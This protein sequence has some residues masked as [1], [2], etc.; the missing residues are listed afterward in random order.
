MLTTL[1]ITNSIKVENQ[2]ICGNGYINLVTYQDY[3]IL[4]ENKQIFFM[5][6]SY[7]N[8]NV[9]DSLL[10]KKLHNNLFESQTYAA[11]LVF[12]GHKYAHVERE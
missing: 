2:C 3:W 12:Y 1:W 7:S 11:K 5:N 9:S 10:T 4:I 8:L 6:I